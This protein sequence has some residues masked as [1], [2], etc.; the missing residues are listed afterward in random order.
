MKVGIRKGTVMKFS[1]W[2]LCIAV[3]LSV[4]SQHAAAL[5]A[6][7]IFKST[8]SSVVVVLASD[9]KGDKNSLGSGVAIA[10]LEIITSCKVVD[11][12]ADI[13][14]TQGSALRKATLHYRDAER[15]L[16]QLHIDDALADAKPVSVT[17][18]S[19]GLES[20]Q[21][22]FVISSPRGLERTIGRAMISGLRESPGASGRLIQIDLLLSGGS[23]GGGVFDQEARLIGIITPQFRQGEPVTYVIPMEWVTELAARTSDR[24]AEKQSSQDPAGT[25]KKVVPGSKPAGPKSGDKWVYE[26]KD[27]SRSVG[28]VV[29]Q[30]TSINGDTLTERI[31]RAGEGGFVAERK[32]GASFNVTRF[33]DIVKLPGGFELSEISPYAP[34][35]LEIRQ[36]QTWGNVPVQI[37]ISNS[38]VQKIATDV[39]AVRKE[40]VSVPAGTF[41]AWR[42]EASATK[43]VAGNTVKMKYTFWY[44]PEMLRTVKMVADVTVQVTYIPKTLDSYELVTFET[45]K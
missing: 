18:S 22:V 20:G 10:P 8:Q 15:D 40:T 37:F 19:K 41:N 35:D 9:A 13:V 27:N 24:L 45:G 14:V 25:E 2:R 31:T 30:V 42:L 11:S 28:K 33:Q 12:A 3:G 34:P 23:L 38:G 29:I 7:D 4:G 39:V 1:G 21:D 16:C 6:R 32:V 17:Q 36:G 26:L 43:V 5:E 44:A